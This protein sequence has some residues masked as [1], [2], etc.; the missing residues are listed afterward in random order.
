MLKFL[1][2]LFSNIILILTCVGHANAQTIVD[3]TPFPNSMINTNSDLNTTGD[4]YKAIP[5]KDRFYLFNHHNRHADNPFYCVDR[6]T[7]TACN[8]SSWPKKLLVDSTGVGTT[9]GDTPESFAILNDRLY[10]PVTKFPPGTTYSGPNNSASASPDSWGMSCFDLVTNSSCGYFPLSTNPNSRNF[11]VAIEGPFEKNGKFYFLDLDM[12]FHCVTFTGVTPSGCGS[13]SLTAFNLPAFADPSTGNGDMHSSGGHIAAVLGPDGSGFQDNIYLTVNYHGNLTEKRAICMNSVTMTPCWSQAKSFSSRERYTGGGPIDTYNFSNYIFYDTS[14]QPVSLC[15]KGSGLQSCLRLSNGDDTSLIHA[16]LNTIMAP[17]PL[18][19]GFGGEVYLE[20]KTYFPDWL[21]SRIFCVDWSGPSLCT[22]F[23]L[24]SPTFTRE[25]AMTKDDAN[26]IWALGHESELWSLDPYTRSVPCNRGSFTQIVMKE[27]CDTSWHDIFIDDIDPSDYSSLIIRVKNNQGVWVEFDVL[28]PNNQ[29]SLS[30]PQFQNMNTL[31]YQVEAVFASGV[32]N[33][34]QVPQVNVRTIDSD[35]CGPSEPTS[36]C[37]DCELC[38]PPW[39]ESQFAKIFEDEGIPGVDFKFR[40]DLGYDPSV[41]S[42]MQNY[43]NYAAGLDP[44]VTSVGVIFWAADCVDNF[45]VPFAACSNGNPS[46][47]LFA[48][49]YS[50]DAGLTTPAPY[51]SIYNFVGNS[52]NWV[53]PYSPIEHDALR[54]RAYQVW[55]FPFAKYADGSIKLFGFWDD[56][57]QTGTVQ[58]NHQRA[59][60]LKP[61]NGGN[62]NFQNLNADKLRKLKGGQRIIEQLRKMEKA[63]KNTKLDP[64]KTKWTSWINSDRQSGNGDYETVSG[65]S[66]A[67]KI[68]SNPVDIQCRTSRN[69]KDWTS[70]GENMTCNVS[71]GSLCSNKQQKDGRCEDY[72]ARFLCPVKVDA[73]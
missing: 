8:G 58:V 56:D 20:G 64:T 51:K 45:P 14:L 3:T 4:G 39:S 12:E 59:F 38:C 10:Y 32:D 55:S 66:K 73:P 44:N 21:N 33:Y 30:D 19:N 15:N 47:N 72:E 27:G 25:Y 9:T 36:G 50:W 35:D 42:L 43:T 61:T 23:P 69:K 18:T 11:Q 53:N 17:F 28:P 71:E 34:T 7:N 67:G 6:N 40:I 49:A 1:K 24:N 48:E 65:L 60:R 22:G 52:W 62:D 26:C 37:P 63:A 31:E 68:C 41:S 57:C 2:I 13:V 16:Q 29:I 46:I 70:N 5:Y 54:N